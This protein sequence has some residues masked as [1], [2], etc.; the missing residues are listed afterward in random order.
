M[1]YTS[2]MANLDL[3]LLNPLD[4]L[5]T[6]GNIANAVSR[7]QL[8]LYGMSR[9]LALCERRW[10]LMQENDEAWFEKYPCAKSHTWLPDVAY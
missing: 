5:R 4:A 6:E 2:D 3:N 8:S 9:V 10:K 1:W 7:L